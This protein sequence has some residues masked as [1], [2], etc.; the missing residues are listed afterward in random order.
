M[1]IHMYIYTRVYIYIYD[2]CI[3]C[4]YIHIYKNDNSDLQP[5]CCDIPYNIVT[6]S[7]FL[8]R[9]CVSHTHTHSPTHTHF[10]N[11]ESDDV[12]SRVDVL[13]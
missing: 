2:T 3:I 7:V 4:I 6:L 1:Y 10:S 11:E 9:V 13:T 5:L 8:T 12:D